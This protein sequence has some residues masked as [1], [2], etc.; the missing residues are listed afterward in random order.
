MLISLVDELTPSKKWKIM[1]KKDQC[2]L[3]K[4]F[5]EFM[6]MLNSVLASSPARVE[7]IFST[8]GL[9]QN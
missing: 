4:D 2:P 1:T 9:V 7:R 3:K 8:F 5:C 6:E